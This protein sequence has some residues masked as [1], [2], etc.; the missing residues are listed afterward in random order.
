MYYSRILGSKCQWRLFANELSQKT[1]LCVRHL[2]IVLGNALSGSELADDAILELGYGGET[3]K[4]VWERFHHGKGHFHSKGCILHWLA[5]CFAKEHG[6]SHEI[7]VVFT[8]EQLASVIEVSGADADSVRG[9]AEALVVGGFRLY[10]GGGFGFNNRGAGVSGSGESV[11]FRGPNAE[12]LLA[13]FRAGRAGDF[14]RHPTLTECIGS[15][16]ELRQLV[17][18]LRALQRLP[19][20]AW[21]GRAGGAGAF[22][23]S[24]A[25]K[26]HE[27]GPTAIR[28][29][30]ADAGITN[31]RG[32]L[33]PLLNKL[34]DECINRLDVAEAVSAAE[35]GNWSKL[36]EPELRKKADAYRLYLVECPKCWAAEKA[37]ARLCYHPGGHSHRWECPKPCKTCSHCLICGGS[38]SRCQCSQVRARDLPV[39]PPIEQRLPRKNGLPGLLFPYGMGKYAATHRDKRGH[40]EWIRSL[41][42]D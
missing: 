15:E 37:S 33:Y 8:A 11:M 32:E 30:C 41:Q 16:S 9:V 42:L 7:V 24:S 14:L 35:A 19:A 26:L 10:M 28:A 18:K 4:S 23:R 6:L 3:T 5:L 34:I 20:A 40:G 12:A 25:A 38:F 22:W 31:S 13:W 29:M 21:S 39:C 36:E 1:R 2:G 27:Y 17:N